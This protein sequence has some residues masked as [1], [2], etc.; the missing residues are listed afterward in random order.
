MTADSPLTLGQILDEAAERHPLAAAVIAGSQRLRYRELRER[1]DVFARGLLALGLGP[2]DHVVVWMPNCIEWNVVNFALA[3]IGAVT[4]TCNSRYRP[5]EVEYLVGQSDARALVMMDRFPPAGVN[6]NE[7]VREIVPDVMWRQ[8]RRL[9]SPKFPEL[10]HVIV[11]GAERDPGCLDWADVEQRGARV[12]PGELERI[13]VQ[14]DDPAEMLYTSGTTGQPKGCLLSHGTLWYKARVYLDLH[15][16]T[17]DDRSLVAVPYFHIFGALGGVV[18]NTLAGSTQVLMETFEPEAAMRHIQDERVTI[19]SGVPTMF[20]TILGH[21]RF[22]QFDL[23][24]LRT[25]TIGAAPMPIEMMRRILDRENGLGMDATVV[26]GLTEA[27]GGTHFTR[28]GDPIDK[29]VSTVGR[30]TPELEDRIVDPTSGRVLGAGEEGEVCVKGPSLMLG[31]YKQDDATA[32]KIRD[33]WLHTGDMGVKDA[34]G[35]LRITGRLTDMIIVGGFNTYPAEIENFYLRHPRILDVSIVGVPDPVMGESV[36]A[37]VIP[38]SGETL[39]AQEIVEFARGTIAN[40]KV[41]KHV[42]IVS[43]FPLTGSGKVQKFKQ[44][45]W[46]IERYGLRGP[47]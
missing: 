27:T 31:Y 7:L 16:W 32:E 33:G 14:P 37:F 41:P 10:R 25:G 29:R 17:A 24:S 18:A 38:K 13:R 12:A 2:G 44:K 30:V 6:Y 43:E 4:V 1:V 36:M 40:F 15:A 23:R 34:E 11:L 46:A 5:F 3:K 39:T 20:I 47:Q 35:Y 9:F 8:D 42:E 45:A 26:Y 22:Q 28:L 19:F 21:P